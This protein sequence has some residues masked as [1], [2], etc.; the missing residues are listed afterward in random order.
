MIRSWVKK[1]AAAVTLLT[2]TALA[3]GLSTGTASAA[4]AVTTIGST[5]HGQVHP[6]A[7]HDLCVTA[8]SADAG[9]GVQLHL[10]QATSI[11]L[12]Q[13]SIIFIK[14]TVRSTRG[15]GLACLSAHP[16]ICLGVG[17]WNRKGQYAPARM[18]DHTQADPATLVHSA[19]TLLR[20]GLPAGGPS[21]FKFGST[22]FGNGKL[23]LTPLS[24]GT[25]AIKFGM[26]LV[27]RNPRSTDV[28]IWNLPRFSAVK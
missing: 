16:R 22:F 17:T 3:A 14:A 2:A 7:R 13:W 5:A 12:Q 10:C 8:E 23:K 4:P 27:F 6:P 24:R 26:D 21:G 25:S 18:Y 11:K 20:Q 19:L 28:S 1:T 15:F 9:A